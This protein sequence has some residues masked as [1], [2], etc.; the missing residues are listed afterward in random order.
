MRRQRDPPQIHERRNSPP[1]EVQKHH[2]VSSQTRRGCGESPV[3]RIVVGHATGVPVEVAPRRIGTVI[4]R[5]GNPHASDMIDVIHR[6]SDFRDRDPGAV[7]FDHEVQVQPR[8]GCA[9][10]LVESTQLMKG[11]AIAQQE[12]PGGARQERRL[13]VRSANLVCQVF[14]RRPSQTALID[15]ELDVVSR[16]AV[17]R[18]RL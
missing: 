15:A 16:C 11:V 1:V 2:A 12:V 9:I 18:R 6:S 13:E 10:H 14:E 4:E 8:S 17:H 7:D 3:V 5:L